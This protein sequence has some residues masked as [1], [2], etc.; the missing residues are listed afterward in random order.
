[1]NTYTPD[2]HAA[3]PRDPGQQDVRRMD[4]WNTT[5]APIASAS[6]V[7]TV[8]VG[9][10]ARKLW[11]GGVAS[12][13]V[14]GLV[15]LVGVL[16][17]RWVFKVPLLAPR[18]DGAFGDV[19]TTALVLAAMAGALVAT[20]LMHVLMLG[21]LRPRLFFGWIVALVTAIMVVFPFGTT[22]ALDAKIATAV[23][24]LVIGVAIGTLVGGVAARAVPRRRLTSADHLPVRYDRGV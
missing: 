11:A 21:T 7:R 14:A 17:S 6:P 19:H 20:G 18:Q 13:I 5:P 16:V 1:M 15:A 9:V 23:V 2:E 8:G 22:A 3:G 10:D 4:A 12:A 24:N